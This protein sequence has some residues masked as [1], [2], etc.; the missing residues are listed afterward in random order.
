[1]HPSGSPSLDSARNSVKRAE[2]DRERFAEIVQE[3]WDQLPP[4]ILARLENV[5]LVIEDR[6][7]A[8]LLR[9]LGLDPHRDTLFGLYS[10]IPLKHRG[11]FY[12]NQPPDTIT[13]YY[14][15]LV[16]AFPYE[17]RLRE[18]I[19]RTIVHEVAHFL[20]MSEGEIRRLGY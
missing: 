10:G 8:R 12:G 5:V 14:R 19:R 6:P 3:E 16:R 1:M 17:R 18:Q 13:I 2:V 7:S 11:A 9:S 4:D 15:P 20:G